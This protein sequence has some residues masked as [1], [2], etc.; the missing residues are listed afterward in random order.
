MNP[1]HFAEFI[2]PNP[3]PYSGREESLDRILKSVRAGNCCRVLGPRYRSKSQILQTAA[4]ALQA[5]GT[6]YA[7]YQSLR[8]E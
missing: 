1:L 4:A 6:H 2:N 8:E 3:L 5:D 7:A